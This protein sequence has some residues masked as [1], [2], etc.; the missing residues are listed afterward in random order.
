MK[1][2]YLAL[3]LAVVSVMAVAAPAASAARW[4]HCAGKYDVGGNPSGFNDFWKSISVR[5]VSCHTGRDITVRYIKRTSG[6]PSRYL[7]RH[8]RIG[9]WTCTLRL[10]QTHDNPYGKVTC[11]TSRGR[12]I[13]FL[14][15]S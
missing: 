3:L 14:G 4:T 2:R 12:Q 1:V 7:N 13:T 8:V 15:K 9:G 10:I 5:Y 6:N 11:T